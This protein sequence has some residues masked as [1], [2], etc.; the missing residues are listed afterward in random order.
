MSLH[1]HDVVRTRTR[2]VG[3]DRISEGVRRGGK[4]GGTHLGTGEN[5][6]EIR[7]LLRTPT[8]RAKRQG[9]RIH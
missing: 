4:N 2:S 5:P 3:A 6:E 7:A 9:E 1:A 8:E